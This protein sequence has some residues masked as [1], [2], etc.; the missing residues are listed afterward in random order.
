[1]AATV[2]DFV[3]MNPP[4]FLGSQVGKDPL[5][6]INEVKKIFGVMSLKGSNR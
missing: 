3:R 6:F 4:K 5:K 1:M 2:C